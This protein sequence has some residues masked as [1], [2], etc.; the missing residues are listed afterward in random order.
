MG[1]FPHEFETCTEEELV[2][3]YSAVVEIYGVKE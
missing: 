3:L 2:F 1:K